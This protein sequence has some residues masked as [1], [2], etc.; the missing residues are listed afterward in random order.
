MSNSKMS[1]MT[2]TSIGSIRLGVQR[3]LRKYYVVIQV[4][5]LHCSIAIT[6][7]TTKIFLKKIAM[8][9]L[10]RTRLD[11]S[12]KWYDW[13]SSIFKDLFKA[14]NLNNDILLQ[15]NNIL[16]TESLTKCAR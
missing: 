4:F 2:R 6:N 5:C 15:N 10:T 3:M 8:Q 12:I 14:S 13:A 7:N 11:L 9:T 1:G 16:C